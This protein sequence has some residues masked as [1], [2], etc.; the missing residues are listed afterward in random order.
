MV[1]QA[2][3]TIPEV[4]LAWPGKNSTERWLDMICA[5]ADGGA[6][7]VRAEAVDWFGGGVLAHGDNLAL[8]LAMRSARL[9]VERGAGG[10]DRA[11]SAD[12]AGAA[13]GVP[14]VVID[15][16][17]A[18]QSDHSVVQV[19]TGRKIEHAYSDRWG[20]PGAYLSCMY[21]RLSLIRDVLSDDGVLFV[22]CDW[23][24]DS[25]LRVV[26]DEVF[27]RACFRNAIAWRRAPNLGAQA[28]GL[29][30]G[31]TSD[32]ILVYSRRPGTKFRGRVP[33]RIEPVALTR[34]GRPRGARWD[35]R[36]KAFF[37][38]APRGDYTDE[39][40]ARLESEGRVL[41]SASGKV[42]IKYYLVQNE[43]GAWCKPM[44]MDTIWTD[45]QVRPLRH[46]SRAEL[47]IGYP[48]QKPEG[49]LERIVSWASAPGDLV[50]DFFAGSGTSLAAAHRLGR[51]WLGCDQSP[52]AIRT[53]IRRLRETTGADVVA[54]RVEF[55]GASPRSPS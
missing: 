11:D 20:S 52:V 37:T 53:M 1:D 5:R 33:M 38:T 29:Q 43:Q 26:L 23:R 22:H 34:S 44:P 45:A 46:C 6:G 55:E 36:A 18:M 16:P 21:L 49:L 19:G 7:L 3:A 13:A 10:A 39:S 15:P 12:S 17:Y 25:W 30:L 14:L 40:I 48:T 4:M 42:T 41:R 28:A 50:A 35:E 54:R 27:G 24:A 8:L 32:T 51:R 31:R 9:R 47:D 2:A